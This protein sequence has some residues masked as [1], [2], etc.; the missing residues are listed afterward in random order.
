MPRN[1]RQIVAEAERRFP[2]RL[3]LAV[4]PLGFGERLTRMHAWLDD[5][6]GADG[7]EITPSG[8]AGI[9]NDAVAI[10][11]SDAAHAAAFALRWCAPAA[12]T[13]G[14]MRPREDEPAPR[15]VAP[16]HSTPVVRR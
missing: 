12:G 13:D 9:V 14:T 16:F 3:R 2:V 11:F 1:S 6:C 5:N 10:Y 8:I 4:P 7:W 15:K